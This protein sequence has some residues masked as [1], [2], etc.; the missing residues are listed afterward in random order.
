MKVRKNMF[1]DFALS[2]WTI[3]K[4][5]LR[6]W[7]RQPANIAS[8][9]VPALCF[10]LVSALGS[11]AVG[12]SPVALV[13]LDHALSAI[14]MQQIFH[15]SDA[16]SVIDATPASA[17][18]L[19]KNIQV[20]AIITIPADFTQ[21]VRAHQASPIDVKVNNL[22]LDFTNDIRRAVPGAVT[23]FYQAQG[24]NSVIKITSQEQDLRSRDIALFQYSV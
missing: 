14:Q 8:T 24:K 19:F 11:A 3:V 20:V 17:Q 9:F 16:V 22:N 6:V 21:R 4:K 23:Q 18:D 5:D 12:R 15:D 2:I 1:R 10:L 13:T 7:I